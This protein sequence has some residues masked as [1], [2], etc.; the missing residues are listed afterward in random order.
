M[1]RSPEAASDQMRSSTALSA[2]NWN[3]VKVPLRASSSQATSSTRT[4]NARAAPEQRVDQPRGLLGRPPGA[5]SGM[6]LAPC[7]RPF[8]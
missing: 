3:G 4:K 8:G 5:V 2:G 1:A 7:Q 6:L